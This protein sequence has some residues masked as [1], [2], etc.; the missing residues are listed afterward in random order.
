MEVKLSFDERKRLLKCYWKVENVVEIQRHWRVEF[1]K[2]PPT[3]VTMTR[4]RDKFEVDGMMQDVLKGRCRRKRSS[5]VN[6]SADAVMQVPT[7]ISQFNPSR[8]LSLATLKNMV[9]DTKP[10]TL[11]E[12]RDQIEHAINDIP[13]ATIQT[14][15]R[16]VRRRCWECTVAEG[17]HFEHVWA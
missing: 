13:L 10:Q 7:S 4:I 2:P 1:G 12:L 8:L 15:C 9:Y 14:V 11:E 6:E 3:K 17:G 5:T 16:Y